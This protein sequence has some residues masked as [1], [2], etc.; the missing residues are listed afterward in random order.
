M[1]TVQQDNSIVFMH[2]RPSHCKDKSIRELQDK[3]QMHNKERRSLSM[4]TAPVSNNP[5]AHVRS[6]SSPAP[7]DFATEP[8]MERLY[9]RIR[10]NSS[11]NV[12]LINFDGLHV[13]T[14]QHIKNIRM[15]L[16]NILKS[17]NKES[18]NVAC[19][20]NYDSFS[21]EDSLLQLYKHCVDSHLQQFQTIQRFTT[22]NWVDD[23]IK[24]LDQSS[25]LITNTTTETVIQS[26]YKIERALDEGTYARVWLAVDYHSNNHVAVKE[27]SKKSLESVPKL[28]HFFD[29]ELKIMSTITD[30]GGHDNICKLMEH[31]EDDASHFL[32]MELCHTGSLDSP[33]NPH[34]QLG[35]KI[36]HKYFVQMVGAL[37]F[38]H[39]KC[40]VV[41]RDLQLSNICLD[42]NDN[43]KIV[44][45]G[46]STFC[47]PDKT[48]EMFCG[49]SSNACPE[50]LTGKPYV[51]ASADVW[52][53]GCCL[54]KM[55]TGY[56]PYQCA[57]KA[58]TCEFMIPLEEEEELSDEV[59]DLIKC[60]LCLDVNKRYTLKDVQKHP[61]FLN[62]PQQCE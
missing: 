12:L 15:S 48:L 41:H 53:L 28:K 36:T 59:K 5:T 56:N 31:V 19:L 43:V 57:Q 38:L 51:G 27:Y 47:A 29:K 23:E 25:N 20:V 26:R 22:K 34:Q 24:K 6:V 60:I 10:Y 21:V 61:W 8:A 62:G 7:I 2:G 14:E 40:G 3:M 54:Y 42:I 33:H 35:E 30:N 44:D 52:G 58:L 17:H 39:N 9:G 46:V 11:L 37:D 45:F 49:N 55:L 50:M 32:I 4:I 1:T 18:K 13:R 16:H